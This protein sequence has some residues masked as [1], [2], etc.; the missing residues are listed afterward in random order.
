MTSCNGRLGAGGSG[1]SGLGSTDRPTFMDYAV[2]QIKGLR[3][4]EIGLC[5]DAVDNPQAFTESGFQ[6][7]GIA[8][9]GPSR[10]NPNLA[11]QRLIDRE[12]GFQPCH[13]SIFPYRNIAGADCAP[14]ALA[15]ASCRES[16]N[17]SRSL[18]WSG[19]SG[20]TTVAL[21]GNAATNSDWGRT[22]PPSDDGTTALEDRF[23]T[24]AD[25][26]GTDDDDGEDD[27]LGVATAFTARRS[28]RP[29][30]Q[31]T[32]VG[33]HQTRKQS[34][35][36]ARLSGSNRGGQFLGSDHPGRPSYT[37]RC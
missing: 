12:G 32:K 22:L 29:A 28:R 9:S 3:L 34:P 35:N 26:E 25:L 4:A 8:L 37:R 30:L 10:A 6:D 1:W 13:I 21:H 16:R 18:R 33:A 5:P 27:N 11:H 15:R 23:V 14:E 7:L 19:W 31:E 2:R 24:P 20:A 36:V 17:S